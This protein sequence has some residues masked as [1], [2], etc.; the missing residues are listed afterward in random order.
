MA[1]IDAVIKEVNPTET[2]GVTEIVSENADKTIQVTFEIPEVINFLK[3]KDKIQ[4]EISTRTSKTVK[5]I[6]PENTIMFSGRVYQIEKEDDKKVA[7]ISFWGL[8]AKITFPPVKKLISSKK[9]VTL[10]VKKLK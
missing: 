3:L 8:K 2:K 6:A 4:I 5:K 10:I 7:Y 1:P 9:E